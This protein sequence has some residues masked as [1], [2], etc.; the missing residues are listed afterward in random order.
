M[1]LI[2][3]TTGFPVISYFSRS[4][5]L[6]PKWTRSRGGFTLIELL[7]VIAII[8]ILIGLLLPAVQKVRESAAR[9][10]CGNNLKQMALG[11]H[12]YNDAYGKLPPGGVTEGNCCGTESRTNWAIEILPFIEQQTLF[13]RYDNNFTN[14]SPQNQFVRE[15]VV[16]TYRCPSDNSAGGFNLAVPASGPGNT[17]GRNYMAGSYRAVSGRANITAPLGW[18]DNSEGAALPVD[19]RGALHTVWAQINLHQERIVAITDGT[20]NTLLLGEYQTKTVPQRRSFWAYTY[21]SYNQ[22]SVHPA[23]HTYMNDF[24]RCEQISANLN[25]DNRPCRRA[26]GSFHSEG[27]NWAMCDGSVRFI[28]TNV[29]MTLLSNMATI[30][31][32]EAQII[33]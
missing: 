17:L 33:R 21:T 23:S 16:K 29:D 13:S 22:S 25:L 15:Q 19:Y 14:E 8:A 1:V 6:S 7:V 9:M 4:A 30:A 32:G 11:C 10:Q 3:L 2:P 18:M 31:G 5:M 27:A 26:F 12:A 20:S 24:T 28:P